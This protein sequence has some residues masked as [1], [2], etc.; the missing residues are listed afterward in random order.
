MDKQAFIKT[1]KE[2][3]ETGKKRNFSQSVDLI[4]TLRDLD[5]KNPENHV[6]IFVTLPKAH[7]KKV[8]IAAL[9]GPELEEKCKELCD[10]T[11]TESQ[12]ADYSDKKKAKQFASE[13][14]FFIAQADIM[15]KVAAA[16]GK[17]LGPRG[18]MPNPKLGS[19]IPAKGAVE[20]LIEK[21]KK[22]V[23]VS[24]KKSPMT[25][26][27]VGNESM[28]DSDIADNLVAVLNQLSHSLPKE[29]N[30]IKTVMIKLTMSK[31]IKVQ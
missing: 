31:P 14:D 2:L 20:P 11:L 16:F 26:V 10:I 3:R 5:M 17:V 25:Q 29:D 21:L 18:K 22:V 8:K 13:Y 23:R 15:T 12:F 4:V 7:S 19:I 27:K 6:D 28:S 1:L 9:V 30:N 24:A